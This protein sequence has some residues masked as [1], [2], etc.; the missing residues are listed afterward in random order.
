MITAQL[1]NV[2][3]LEEFNKEIR[4]QQEEGHGKD[5]CQIFDAIQKYMKECESYLELG[6]N[7]GGTASAALLTKPKRVHLVDWRMGPYNQFLRPIA[8][9]FAADNNITLT[10]K[11]IDSR[12]LAAVEVVDMLM[13]DSK[14]TAPHMTEELATHGHNVSKY[15]IAHDTSMV[16]KVPNDSLYQVL[17]KFAKTNGWRIIERGTTNVGYTV[18]KKER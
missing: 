8:E 13:I 7:Q 17:A 1:E 16:A 10:A 3:T 11:E 2:T 9:K 4:R 18:L 5:Y 6:T 14:H 12:S 15:I